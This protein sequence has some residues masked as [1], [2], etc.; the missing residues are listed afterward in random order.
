MSKETGILI[1]TPF[2]EPN[3]GGVE[4]HLKDLTDYLRS[5]SEYKI[6]VLTY[7]P[8]T[9]KAK[10]PV[11]ENNGCLRIIRIPWAG[12]NLFH[13]LEPYP[14]L[15]FL[16][17][18]PLLFLNAFILLLVRGRSITVI[19]AQGF[20]AAF[21]G[22][23]LSPLFSKRLVVSIHAIYNL[24]PFSRLSK[25]IKWTLSGA[26]KVL[27]LS[28]ASKEELVRIG[29]K[30]KLIGVYTYWVDQ[31]RFFPILREAARNS[32]GWPDKFTVFFAGRL[33][34][35]K[36]ADILLEAAEQIREDIA[37]VF[38]GDGPFEGIVR[39]ASIGLINVKYLGKVDNK[40]L[41]ACYSAA[42]IV[43][44][45]SKYDEGF[46]R[47]ILESLSCGTPVVASDRGGIPEA[48]DET[49]GVLV[50]PDVQAFKSAILKLFYDR[51]KLKALKDNCR[52]YAL[53]RFGVANARIITDA[54]ISR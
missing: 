54:Y 3:T 7:Q 42:D 31:R 36:G 23:L 22:R 17:L 9:T 15:E 49:V 44:V 33:I 51:E 40:D 19:H 43:C 50:E 39:K 48:V 46:G 37:F 6:F 41:P 28:S 13:K 47:V 10:A 14:I 29:L 35:K 27:T 24:K 8:L 34:E 4:T 1:L 30:D 11:F 18:T 21:I 25:L 12:Y 53:K 32:L 16:Y 20:N 26:G 5:A 45:P 52:A 2:Y 38:A